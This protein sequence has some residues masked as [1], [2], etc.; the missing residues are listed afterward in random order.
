VSTKKK[1]KPNSNRHALRK[2]DGKF[3][4]AES[5]QTGIERWNKPGALGFAFWVRDIE[6]RILTSNNRYEP[7]K[8]TRKQLDIIKKVLAVDDQNNF[9]HSMSLQ[10]APRRHGKS[11]L[12]SLIILWLFCSRKNFVIQLS[13]NSEDHSRRVQY[14]LLK[15]II[16]NT[17]KL[18]LMIP[19]KDILQHEIKYS[20][21]GNVI[22]MQTGVSFSTSF[23]DRL[24][25][26][27]SS[28]AH[29]AV[30]MESFNALQS[31]LLD[32]EGSL[33]LMDCNVD[34][35]DG[36]IH[37]LE[38][39]AETDKSIYC[40]HV[41]YKDFAEYCKKAPPWID[42]KKAARLEKTLLEAEFKRDAL[43]QGS[44]LSLCQGLPQ[45]FQKSLH[46]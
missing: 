11:V 17:P 30:S 31:S 41:S 18:R 36:P 45:G 7:F 43:G 12:F 29:A 9:L 6:P 26:L 37:D 34:S 32:S 40:N 44:C 24:S 2:A 13:G 15:R 14:R 23:G 20:K 8:P 3:V 39:L 42:L 1:R 19:D 27:W 16:E 35:L 10:I 5:K 25:L 38:R 33:C 22:Q 4:S 46:P 28:D 21:R